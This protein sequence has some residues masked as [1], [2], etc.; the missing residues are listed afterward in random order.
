MPDP[1]LFRVAS[2]PSQGGGH[3]SRSGALALALKSHCPVTMVLDH[4][5][6]DARGR[7]EAAG[8]SCTTTGEEG[9]GPWAGAVVDGYRFERS[10]LGSIASKARP[11]VWF[12]DFLDPPEIAD[13]VINA[14]CGD[15][16]S[17]IKGRPALLGPRYALIDPRFAVL[18]G[19]DR[20]RPVEKILI[21][22]GRLDPDNA[23][24]KCLRALALLAADG[25]AAKVIL[26][27]SAAS[28]HIAT[29]R[30]EAAGM[31]NVS[32]ATEHADMLS[33]LGD[34]DLVV[35]AGGVSL[36]ERMA[37]GVPSASLIIADNQRLSVEGAAASGGTLCV[38]DARTMSPKDIAAAIRP[39]LTNPELRRDMALAGRRL[40]DGMGPKRV[41]SCLVEFVRS[42][43]ETK[44]TSIASI[45][46]G[47]C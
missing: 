40:I 27:V 3:V 37:A 10:E 5:S 31:A 6:F 1:W 26:M 41:A 43:R 46:E 42:W 30:E 39:L 9:P 29:L 17:E 8:L 47:R 18:P 7:L 19:R 25:I 20:T 11:V 14:M 24:G 22:F 44:G 32:V 28:P 33:R 15:S 13:L 36:L 16:G 4:D 2:Q 12:D 35:G 21:S 45:I 23:A 38:G 34:C